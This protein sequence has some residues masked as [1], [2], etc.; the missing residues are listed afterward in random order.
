[1]GG[2]VNWGPGMPFNLTGSTMKVIIRQMI[3]SVLLIWS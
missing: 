3:G 1:L 2:Q